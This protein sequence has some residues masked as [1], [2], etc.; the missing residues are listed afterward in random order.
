MPGALG[1][2]GSNHVDYRPE[3]LTETINFL[4]FSE[5]SFVRFK[6]GFIATA[7]L[8]KT[9]LKGKRYFEN[10][11]YRILFIGDLVDYE[12]VPWKQIHNII[13]S[14][15]F[16]LLKKFEGTF[17]IV[18]ITKKDPKI[19][20][21]SDRRSQR[22]IYYKI[23]NETLIFSTELATFCRLPEKAEFRRQWLYDYFFF[24]YPVDQTTFL[25][26]V[27]RVP[28]ATVLTYDAANKDL[29][30]SAYAGLFSAK[31]HIL[32]GPDALNLAKERV[33]DRI[34]KYFL[35]GDDTA[36]ALTEGWDARTMLSLA[37]DLRRVVAFTYG[38]PGCPDL[39]G[40]NNT[41]KLAKI[42]HR[43]IL[44]D[45]QFVKKLPDYII[46]SAYLSSSLQIA[47]RATLLYVYENLTETGQK[48]SH[49]I[50]GIA[51][52]Q[53]FRGHISSPNPISAGIEKLFRGQGNPLNEEFWSNIFTTDYHDLHEYLRHR[54]R[55]LEETFGAFQ[56]PLHHLL[57]KLYVQCPNYFAGEFNIA[58]QFS[59][60]RVPAWDSQIIDLALS[61]KESALSYSIG[62]GKRESSQK[63][64]SLQA[65]LISTLSPGFAKIP[66]R[67]TR[68]DIVLKS[69]FIYKLYT[70]YRL[71]TK[72]YAFMLKNAP[73]LEDWSAWFNVVHKNFIDHLIFS[74]NSLVQ[75]YISEGF[76]ESQ[77]T[78]RNTHWIGKLISVELL[79]HL[80]DNRWRM[81]SIDYGR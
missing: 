4:S 35:S 57:F 81:P 66:V 55:Y 64:N 24:N 41:A 75:R 22:P 45:D 10:E 25:E 38:I 47:K 16:S 53:M 31:N 77:K 61:I 51:F 50:S 26:N 39:I 68:P 69:N 32:D 7:M 27:F 8:P 74:D 12:T 46:R 54:L 14:G 36:C 79:L 29:T 33:A 48:F 20:I 60:L 37:P 67:N 71:M 2:L 62:S 34:P 1:V 73:K 58:E 76:L 5:P 17:A 65:Y 6:D 43:Q 15:E 78:N 63:I 19:F 40:A 13:E 30:E 44:F 70:L 9:P 11:D 28:P 56:T 18:G 42:N 59:T 21:V 72:N 3:D 80:I 49:I 23:E 52:D